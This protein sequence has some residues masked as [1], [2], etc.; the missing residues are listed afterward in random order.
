MQLRAGQLLF[1]SQLVDAFKDALTLDIWELKTFF[2][3]KKY[4][5]RTLLPLS[6]PLRSNVAKRSLLKSFYFLLMQLLVPHLLNLSIWRHFFFALNHVSFTPWSGANS[7]YFNSLWSLHPAYIMITRGNKDY[8]ICFPCRALHL[9][10]S[11]LMKNTGELSLNLKGFKMS[12]NTPF[13]E[14]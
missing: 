12:S 6:I 2:K 3:E 14:G 5:F 13:I 8:F 11:I 10:Q 1:K 4:F 7:P 9:T